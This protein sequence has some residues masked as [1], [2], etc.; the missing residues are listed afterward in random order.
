MS[1]PRKKTLVAAAVLALLAGCFA[2]GPTERPTLVVLKSGKVLTGE[3]RGVANGIIDFVDETGEELPLPRTL[4]RALEGGGQF[5]DPLILWRKVARAGAQPPANFVRTAHHADGSGS[6]DV[7]VSAYEQPG[8]GRRVYLVGAVHIAHVETFV[9]QQGV[10]DAMD[11]VLW[12]GVGAEEEPDPK[13]LERFDVL[14]K[15]Q[16]MLQ[17]V[18]DL[19]FQLDNINYDR[20][21]WRNSDMSINEI[22]AA[23]KQRGLSMIPHEELFLAVFGTIFKFVDPRSIP[24]NPTVGRMYRASIAPL[25]A[26]IESLMN[27]A[28]TQGLKEVLIELRNEV[29][30]ADL[31]ELLDAPGPERIGI[32]YGAGHLPDMDRVL[33]DEL[34]LEFL[35]VH[36]I[37]AWRY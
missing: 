5:A 9:A 28:G 1:L 27:Q 6:L 24:R 15:A 36:W 31:R 14:F 20:S 26:D 25:M 23:L 2:P 17:K 11:I 18:L 4:V 16:M 7:G 22:E 21:F 13:V 35:G 34:G 3:V 29:V 37:P 12:E 8:T 19:D 10:L 33:R 30:M 32:Y